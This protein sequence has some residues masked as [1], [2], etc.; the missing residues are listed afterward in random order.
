[1]RAAPIPENEDLRLDVLKR[2]DILDTPQ[3]KAFDDI[4][5]LASFICKTPVSQITFVDKDRL[6]FKANFGVD[7]NELPRE[8]GFCAH[9]IFSD[10]FFEIEDASN[11]ERFFDNPLITGEKHVRFYAGYPLKSSDGLNIGTI[12]VLDNK[13]NKLNEEQRN[14]L[15]ILA[16]RASNELELRLQIHK[17]KELDIAQKDMLSFRDKFLSILTHDLRSPMTSI[18][19]TISMV[20]NNMLDQSEIKEVCDILKVEVDYTNDLLENLLLWFKAKINTNSREINVF[21][22][23][24]LIKDT[25]NL[26]SQEAFKKGIS[27]VNKDQ[28]VPVYGDFEMIKLAVRNLVN[29]AIKFS[30]AGD[31]IEIGSKIEQSRSVIWVKDT[32]QGMSGEKLNEILSENMISPNLTHKNI[33]GIGLG[34]ILINEFMLQNQGRIMASSHPNQ[35]SNFRLE[36]PSARSIK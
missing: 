33:K 1:M 7:L 20:E 11:D 26:Y 6:F 31:E 3:E 34:M 9:T 15:E 30:Q 14:A 13:P 32:G 12:C 2:Y 5:K 8:I 36:F 4:A 28:N 22:T 17:S 25:I 19:S 10:T 24:S 35:G 16:D 27:I 23:S 29:N 18:K 21:L